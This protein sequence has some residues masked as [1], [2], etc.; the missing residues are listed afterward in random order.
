MN[1]APALGSVRVQK[2]TFVAISGFFLKCQIPPTTLYSVI[3]RRH[4]SYASSMTIGRIGPTTRKTKKQQEKKNE[5]G[6]TFGKQNLAAVGRG[7]PNATANLTNAVS[8]ILR[9]CPLGRC[10]RR[11]P[12]SSS[13]H[14]LLLLSL[15]IPSSCAFVV[16]V[17]AGLEIELFGC[18]AKIGNR[19]KNK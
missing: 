2:F 19:G 3:G 5:F 6:R 7:G 8:L 11:R 9:E 16:S 10:R 12:G 14:M 15:S 13:C 1:S 17:A 4:S 18:R